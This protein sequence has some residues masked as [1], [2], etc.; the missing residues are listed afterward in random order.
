MWPLLVPLLQVYE[1]RCGCLTRHQIYEAAKAS[2]QQIFGLADDR[3]V[4]GILV[5]EIQETARGKQCVAVAAIGEAPE[6]AKRELWERVRGWA[7]EIGCVRI[8]I[9]GRKGWA[10]W[11]RRLRQTGVILEA[12]L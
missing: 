2:R 6:A 1:K 9:Q 10:R 3:H 11:D 5:T 7:K 4:Y 8:Q 12:P